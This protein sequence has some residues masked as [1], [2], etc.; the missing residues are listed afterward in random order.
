MRISKIIMHLRTKLVKMLAYLNT[1]KYMNEYV[2]LLRS[3]GMKI[4]GTPKFIAANATFDGSYCTEIELGDNITISKNVTFLVHDFSITTAVAVLQGRRIERGE[5]EIY[6]KKRI[7]I[8]K[9]NFIGANSMILPG[10]NI[11]DNCII[12]AGAVVKG[13]IPE[14]SIVIGNPARIIGKVDEWAKAQMEKK[15][16]FSC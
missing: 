3:R 12:G 13:N 2:K 15:E 8:G 6:F 7:K 14:N 16:Y 4:Y 11:G 5:G 1:D 9:N 10:T